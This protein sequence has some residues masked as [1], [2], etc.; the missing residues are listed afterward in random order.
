MVRHKRIVLASVTLAAALSGA[1]LA[2]AAGDQR[3]TGASAERL[4]HT[5]DGVPIV[6][7][8]PECRIGKAPKPQHAQPDPSD[9]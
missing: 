3:I 8:G 6:Q 1:A 2:P 7:S 4:S 5:E 9:Y